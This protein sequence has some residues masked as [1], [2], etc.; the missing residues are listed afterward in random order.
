M[1]VLR[2]RVHDR[3]SGALHSQHRT[4]LEYLFGTKGKKNT[5]INEC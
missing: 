5:I 3:S 2:E 4:L 1:T